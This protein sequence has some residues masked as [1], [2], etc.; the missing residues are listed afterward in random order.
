MAQWLSFRLLQTP[1]EL[2]PILDAIVGCT[3]GD[4]APNPSD[5]S[6]SSSSSEGSQVPCIAFVSKMVAFERAMLPENQA[7]K[8]SAEEL[9]KR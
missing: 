4:A 5:G 3:K 8:A 6:S 7:P 2:Q 9:R 1:Q